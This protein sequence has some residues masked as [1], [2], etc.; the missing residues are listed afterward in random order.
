MIHRDQGDWKQYKT[1]ETYY[2]WKLCVLSTECD[3]VDIIVT[4]SIGV[5]TGCN[6][7]MVKLAPSPII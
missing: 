5:G 2:L 6:F 3:L 7:L 1:M 4:I